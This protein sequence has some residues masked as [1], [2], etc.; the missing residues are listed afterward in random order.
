MALPCAPM[1]GGQKSSHDITKKL[2]LL[3][4]CTVYFISSIQTVSDKITS[5]LGLNTLTCATLEHPCYTQVTVYIVEAKI[6]YFQVY[7]F[8][9]EMINGNSREAS[10]PGRLWIMK[11]NGPTNRCDFSEVLYM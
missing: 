2:L 6:R 5:L 3:T 9:A 11:L 1:F 8:L 10:T 7:Y 4:L